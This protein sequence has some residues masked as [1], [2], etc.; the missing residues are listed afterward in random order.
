M[1]IWINAPFSVENTELI[2]KSAL[3][4]EIFTDTENVD[5]ADIIIGQFPKKEF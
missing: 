5:G 4:C 1:K 2:K 3:N